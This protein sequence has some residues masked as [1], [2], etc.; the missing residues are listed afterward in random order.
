MKGQVLALSELTSGG[1]HPKVSATQRLDPYW[2]GVWSSGALASWVS[3]SS[4]RR[5]QE[6]GLARIPVDLDIDPDQALKSFTSSHSWQRKVELIGMLNA[7]RT[8]TAEQLAALTG[9][10]TLARRS[11]VM[12]NAFAAGLMDQG[13]STSALSR[14]QE[15]ARSHLFRPSA[16]GVLE[17]EFL[18]HL[19]YPERVA[20]GG[21]RR[22]RVG[23]QYDRHNI[24][25]T[26]LA[27]RAA[28]FTPI[29]AAMGETYASLD[30]LLGS[31]LGREAIKDNSAA[32][33][34]LV[35]PDGMRVAIELTAS[36]TSQFSKKVRRWAEHLSKVSMSLSGL[37]VLFIGAPPPDRYPTGARN[38]FASQMAKAIRGVVDDYPG[39]PG[40]RPA[41]RIGMAMW[42]DYFPD[43][44]QVSTDFLTLR[45]RVP[46]NTKGQRWNRLGMLDEF[47]IPFA[48]MDASRTDAIL[49]GAAT[50]ISSPVWL[51]R[52][53]R[54]YRM[55]DYAMVRA[56][57]TDAPIPVP[58]PQ[59]RPGF[60]PSVRR[61]PGAL[62]KPL[63]RLQHLIP[64]DEGT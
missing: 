2:D 31:G 24:L 57:F 28:E 7:W 45:A 37:T 58:L 34:V 16:S 15:S 33:A 64:A 55:H 20:V 46:G 53:G 56:G 27:L 59:H 61:G 60:D 18:D 13:I 48:P 14:T 3:A 9:S 62:A 51:R 41:D 6:A 43:S 29:A 52:T 35:R 17:R 25:T 49:R 8:A 10:A 21:G 44:G 36:I 30:M 38:T 4:A 39:V 32:D 19:T 11:R 63:G 5:Q 54:P 23:G 42:D 40:T 26:E 1:V 12:H 47:D 22:L 50:V